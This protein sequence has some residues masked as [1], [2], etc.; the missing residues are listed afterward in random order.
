MYILNKF[1]YN[2]KKKHKIS[3][4]L[5]FLTPNLNPSLSL[6]IIQKYQLIS[7][8]LKIYTNFHLIK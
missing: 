2:N 7:H 8:N 3:L 4:L 1:K 5:N 6:T